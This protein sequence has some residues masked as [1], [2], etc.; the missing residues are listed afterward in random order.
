MWMDALTK[1]MKAVNVEFEILDDDKHLLVGY[2]KS[3][4]RLIFD[5]KMNFTRKARWV[6]YGH[7]TPDP[8]TSNYSGVVSRKAFIYS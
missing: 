8:N 1:E 4:G 3:R 2:T 5:F 6:K 7:L